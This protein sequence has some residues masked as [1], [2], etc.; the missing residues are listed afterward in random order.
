MNKEDILTQYKNDI[1]NFKRFGALCNLSEKEINQKIIESLQNIKKQN[2]ELYISFIFYLK[3]I[4]RI[5]FIVVF[6]ILLMF[7]FISFILFNN[8]ILFNF[9][10]RHIQDYIYPSM[11]LLRWL[12]LPIIHTFPSLTGIFKYYD[13]SNI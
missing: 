11:K 7:I 1:E 2:A 8:S 6:I 4:I 10:V 5:L 9:F 12:T 3:Q 13:M